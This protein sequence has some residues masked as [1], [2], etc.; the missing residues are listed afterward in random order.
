MRGIAKN[1]AAA[2]E[3][4]CGASV[5]S[6][7][8]SFVESS[9]RDFVREIGLSDI[10]CLPA[11]LESCPEKLRKFCESLCVPETWFFRQPESFEFLGVIAEK[12]AAEGRF[13][14]VLCAPCSIGC[15]AFSIAAVIAAAGVDFEIEAFDYSEK[16]I[17]VAKRAAY[18]KNCFRSAAS[19]AAFQMK[20]GIF[21]MPDS[22][23]KKI[24]FATANI[25]DD[26][27]SPGLFD[28]IFCR[29]LA[30]YL[31]E[32]SKK[33]L[34]DKIL[35]MS[36]QGAVI[37]TGHADGFVVSDS[38]F[39]RAGVEG[40]FAVRPARQKSENFSGAFIG[41]NRRE[42]L[43]KRAKKINKDAVESAAA[44][45]DQLPENPDCSAARALADAGDIA[46]ARSECLKMLAEYP[47]SAEL[48]MLAAEIFSAQGDLANAEKYFR[49][50]RYVDPQNAD[51]ALGF[52][53]VRRRLEGRS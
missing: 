5:E 15:E 39:E 34:F 41:E 45:L 9:A 38:R 49:R 10:S 7:G 53:L 18:G 37:F 17:G 29:N 30:I 11:E 1:L 48:N 33:K 23:K 12:A 43:K 19:E 52:K 8:D 32:R 44:V 16:L 22:L 28:I 50:A 13:L 36:A 47:D 42:Q 51:A 14:R 31:T 46:S 3:K 20:N 21:E 25:L 24:K 26:R 35:S 27:F 4:G 6:F 40:A 2:V